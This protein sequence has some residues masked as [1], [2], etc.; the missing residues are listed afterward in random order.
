[1]H[2][3]YRIPV[4]GLLR[5][6]ANELAI[7]FASA[8]NAAER[9]N[10]QLG[11]RPHVNAHPFNAI[12]K[13]ACNFGW[14]WGPELVT[15]GIWRPLHLQ[16]W[17]TARLAA[18]RP[19]VYVDGTTGLLRLNVDVERAAGDRGPLVLEVDVAGIRTEATVPATGS[20]VVVEI[21]VDDVRLWW[22]HG[23]GEQPLYRV[24]VTLCDPGGQLD[25]W[26]ARVGFRTI[27]L[28]TTPD[29]HGTPFTLVVNGTP[30][31]ARGVNW[32]PDDC[33]PSRVSRQRYAERLGQAL[34]ANVNLVRV[35]GGGI[36]ES[37]DFYDIC[38]ELGLLVWQ[39]FLFAC[40]AYA[41]EEPLRSEVEAEAREAVTRLSRHPSL[42]LWNGCNENIWGHADW[43]WQDSLGD[44]T[45]GWGYYT[46]LLPSIVAELDPTRPYSPGSPYSMTPD[47]HPERPRARDDAHLGRLERARLHRLPRLRAAVRR[48]VRLPGPADLG[49][50][51]ACHPRPAADARS[52]RH[53][54]AP[55]GRGRQRQAGPWPGRTP[56]RAADL[57]RLA[58]GHLAEP[59]A[60]GGVRHRA[61]PVLVAGLHGHVVWQLNDCWPVTSW[62]AVDGDGRRK[63]LWYA[64]RRSYRDRLL[65][66]QPRDG[67]STGPFS[68][69]RGCRST[70]KHAGSAPSAYLTT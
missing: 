55:E 47:V 50:A 11:P 56:A 58:L 24:A 52:A 32:I 34:D 19:L 41:E 7:T 48:R 54:G 12:R 9:A 51:H 27:A 3:S 37:E 35:W 25:S 10:E 67:R 20:S 36:Y 28:H 43:G 5:R 59:G 49:H 44:R 29:E 21:S 40:A 14:D 31:F 13:M 18:V 15:A 8:L 26:D 22:P 39:D 61:L 33:F 4:A 65:T 70:S 46:D 63:P 45:W 42:V 17:R 57:R 2:R 68:R 16:T 69:A 66:L 38:D 30:V 23:Y 6:G 62:A 53:A 64:L 1:M 60:C